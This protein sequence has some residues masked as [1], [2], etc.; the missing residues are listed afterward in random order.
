MK[1][2]YCEAC[3]KKFFGN[4]R[5]ELYY[6]D[7]NGL[8]ITDRH[9]TYE[10]CNSCSLELKKIM[11]ETRLVNL[12]TNFAD[13]FKKEVAKKEEKYTIKP[14][15]NTIRNLRIIGETSLF[16]LKNN[17]KVVKKAK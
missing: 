11:D 3:H 14:T 10:L 1:I 2:C 9:S 5:V 12:K 16:G 13:D 7:N 4:S 15:K 6:S 8:L 17:K